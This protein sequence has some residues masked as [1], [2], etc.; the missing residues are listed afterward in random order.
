MDFEIKMSLSPCGI[1]YMYHISKRRIPHPGQFHAMV[2]LV[3]AITPIPPPEIPL[4]FKMKLLT[5][6]VYQFSRCPF[7]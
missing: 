1:P 5:R 6:H 7:N 3:L 4:H 2:T